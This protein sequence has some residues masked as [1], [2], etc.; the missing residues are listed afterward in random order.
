[1][2]RWG[3][4]A[5]RHSR[6]ALPPGSLRLFGW[7]GAAGP[8]SPPTLPCQRA[9]PGCPCTLMRGLDRLH[10]RSLQVFRNLPGCGMMGYSSRGTAPR[11]AEGPWPPGTRC[12]Q[13]SGGKTTGF[14]FRPAPT[15][16][17]GRARPKGKGKEGNLL[18]FLYLN[19]F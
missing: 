10:T 16:R 11:P 4:H 7:A 13:V 5:S 2:Q 1:M 15:Q 12:S 19:C 9:Q 18:V 17:E 3:A 14:P 6:A 8:Q